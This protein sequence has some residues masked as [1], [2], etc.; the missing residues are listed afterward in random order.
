MLTQEEYSF[1]SITE[2]HKT[3]STEPKSKPYDTIK[4]NKGDSIHVLL[5]D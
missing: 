4:W 3:A 1:G 2:A 5:T